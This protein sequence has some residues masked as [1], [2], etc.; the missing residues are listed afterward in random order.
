MKRLRRGRLVEIPPEWVGRTT[1]PQTIRKR[2]SKGLRKLRRRDKTKQSGFA[3][4]FYWAWKKTGMTRRE[5][6]QFR[7]IGI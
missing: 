5:R 1:H 7:K 2:A 4:E 3:M 6:D